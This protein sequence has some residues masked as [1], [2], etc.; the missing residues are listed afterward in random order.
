MFIDL[1]TRFGS[2]G[3]PKNDVVREMIRLKQRKERAI[4][5][6]I[7]DQTPSKANLHYWTDFLHQD[8]PVLTGA[9]RLARKLDLPVVYADV[10]QKARGYYT[11]EVKLITDKPKETPEFYITEKYARMME[12]TILRDPAGW[13]WTHRRWKH[14]REEKA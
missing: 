1:R 13:L 14:K 9:E 5:V 7:A 11:I 8:T 3:I 4:G 6:F 12:E 10:R 2:L